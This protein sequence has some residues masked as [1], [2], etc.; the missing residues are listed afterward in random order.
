M[1]G[2]VPTIPLPHHSGVPSIELREPLQ[3]SDI[4]EMLTTVS[5]NLLERPLD[6]R[7][8]FVIPNRELQRPDEA[9]PRRRLRLATT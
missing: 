8:P 1:A 7:G 9:R 6:C 4:E 3:S 5:R 2:R